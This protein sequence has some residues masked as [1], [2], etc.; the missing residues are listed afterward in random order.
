MS[1][2]NRFGGALTD[3]EKEKIDRV[4]WHE[5]VQF[6]KRQQWAVTTAGVVLFGAF[7]AIVRNYDMSAWEKYLAVLL[8]VVGVGAG[9]FFLD[10]LQNGLANVRHALDP[11]DRRAATRGGEILGLHKAILVAS[12]AVVV[13]VFLSKGFQPAGLE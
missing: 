1:D 10:D 4:A 7:L 2:Q 13:W 3:Q 5:Q 11:C 8:I 9:C 12:A 6:L